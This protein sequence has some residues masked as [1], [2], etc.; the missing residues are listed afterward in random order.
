MV[1]QWTDHVS[2][3][4]ASGNI[5]GREDILATA[6]H[7]FFD[8]LCKPIAKPEECTF[9]TIV[10]AQEITRPITKI[11][12]SGYR[13]PAIPSPDVDWAII[14]LGGA[15]LPKKVLPYA[16]GDGNKLKFGEKLLAVN[17][18]NIDFYEKR[19]N[20]QKWFGKS[21]ADAV[22]SMEMDRTG[23][24]AVNTPGAPMNSGGALLRDLT[25]VAL[26]IRGVRELN[27]EDEE[28]IALANETGQ[29]FI[30]PKACVFNKDN[31][32]S[33]YLLFA[34]EFRAAVVK[35]VGD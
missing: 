4:L 23:L 15:A 29:P 17:G 33:Y 24:L 25:F 22:V 35:A 5:L 3:V 10:N 18:A 12:A 13:C 7:L 16:I 6:A 9:R 11:L 34:G 1:R 27:A 28:A 14:A 8:E 19:P 26:H 32:A 21:F 2:E 20:G 31:C 30:R